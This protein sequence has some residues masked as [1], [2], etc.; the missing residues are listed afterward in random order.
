MKKI[1]VLALQGGVVE[2]MAILEQ[3]QGVQVVSVRKVSDLSGLLGLIIPGGES[4]A[5][6]KLLEITQ[7]KVPLKKLIDQGFPIFGTCAGLILLGSHQFGNMAVQVERNAFGSQLDSFDHYGY[8]ESISDKPICMRFVRAPKI[9]EVHSEQVQVLYRLEGFP[10]AVLQG[11]LLATA[12]HPELVGEVALHRFFVEE[13]CLG[14]T[15][16]AM[17][18]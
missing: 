10:V 4:T 12:F 6:L 1:G 13:L 9:I 7:L 5:L 11:N 18:N 14:F 3:I 16:Q 15:A 17:E 8:I 2:H